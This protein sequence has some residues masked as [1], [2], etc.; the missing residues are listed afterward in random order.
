MKTMTRM[1]RSIKD[2]LIKYVIEYA[3]RI[4]E[5]PNRISMFG[6]FEPEVAAGYAIN[7][8]KQKQLTEADRKFIESI[9][10][11]EKIIAFF[12]DKLII[13]YFMLARKI[14]YYESKSLL[15]DKGTKAF[16]ETEYI[17]IDKYPGKYKDYKATEK[18]IEYIK[19]FGVKMKHENELSGREASLIISCLKNPNK[20]RPFYYTYY[21]T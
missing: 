8:L 13:N 4:L 21:I 20:T 10:G 5:S 18:Q 6:M 3:K 9:D 7:S 16:E 15:I 11:R 14:T 17:K 2:F 1:P 19:S 12:D